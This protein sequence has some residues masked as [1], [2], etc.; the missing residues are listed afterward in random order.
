MRQTYYNAIF[1]L[2]PSKKKS[3]N[4]IESETIHSE[5]IRYF[6][7]FLQFLFKNKFYDKKFAIFLDDNE[8]A[9]FLINESSEKSADNNNKFGVYILE[10]NFE[11]TK[12]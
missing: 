12:K 6:N 5:R 8:D 9:G 7:I 10:K 2:F 3:Q 11:V 4:K 1:P